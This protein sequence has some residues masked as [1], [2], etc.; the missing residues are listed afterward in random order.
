MNA[1]YTKGPWF[2][3]ETKGPILDGKFKAT[4]GVWAQDRFDAALLSDDPCVDP[5][6]EKWLC[7]VW[8]VCSE[9]DIA[10][11]RLIAA[12]PEL[13][14]A[15]VGLVDMVTDIRGINMDDYA[16]REIAA[17]RAAIAKAEGKE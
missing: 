11:A 5:D 12:S 9:Q 10:N 2:V 4:I 17:A 15:L 1:S 14:V 3:D 7:G 8:G 16:G 13:L 6:D